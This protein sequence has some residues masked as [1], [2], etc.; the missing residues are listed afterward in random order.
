MFAL[1]LVAFTANAQGILSKANWVL[2][3]REEFDTS[4]ADLK[5]R[6]TIANGPPADSVVN[7]FTPYADEK[8][9]LI[10]DGCLYF[11]TQKLKKPIINPDNRQVYYYSSGDMQSKF[12]ELPACKSRNDAGYLYGMFEIRCKL[13]RKAGQYTAY[14]LHSIT[15]PAQEID[16]FEQNGRFPDYFFSTVHYGSEAEKREEGDNYYYSANLSDDFHTWTVVWTPTQITW[17]FDNEELRTDTIAAHVPG[18]NSPN[19]VER[20]SYMKMMHQTGSGL[21]YPDKDEVVFEPFVVD[22]IRI[23]KP[24]GY[25]PYAGYLNPEYDCWYDRIKQLYRNTP[26]M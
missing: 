24:V 14:W 11:L 25:V 6:W 26:Y 1:T 8:N 21:N 17:F 15:S 23:Y 10:M 19:M 12:D 16:V 18:A 22:Y 13:P 4:L 2:V 5:T 3:S 20:C 9:V 7:Y